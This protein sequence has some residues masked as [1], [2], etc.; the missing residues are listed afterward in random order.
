MALIPSSGRT[1]K[2]T[3]ILRVCVFSKYFLGGI[4]SFDPRC[5]DEMMRMARKL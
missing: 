4:L 2:N 5:R 3:I 1:T